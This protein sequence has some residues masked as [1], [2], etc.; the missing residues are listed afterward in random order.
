M[1]VDYVRRVSSDHWVVH[2]Q[3]AS[4]SEVRVEVNLSREN[5]RLLTR[6]DGVGVGKAVWRSLTGR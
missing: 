3:G 4:C 2:E 1:S 5:A 6:E